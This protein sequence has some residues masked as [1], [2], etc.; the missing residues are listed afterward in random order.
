M[1][2]Y[3]TKTESMQVGGVDTRIRSLLD[4]QQYAD[5]QGVALRAGIS[6]ASWPLFGLVWPSALVLAAHVQ[7]VPLGARRVL[8]IGCGLAL[9]SLV[10]HRR[11]GQVTASDRH[12]LA[13]EFLLENLRLNAMAALP[14]RCGDWL[15]RN[16]DLGRF[17]L[18]V[19]SDVLYERDQP[20]QL[21]AF[22][23]RHAQPC[24]EVI[25][26]D[27]D[28]G[29]RPAF[30]RNMLALGFAHSE[31]RIL[32]MP[33]GGGPYRGRLLNYRRQAPGETGP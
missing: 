7:H 12:P 33:A 15:G 31:S 29:N 20:D 18:I 32:A 27:P 21:S 22:I 2:G 11:Q 9:A 25:I 5:P 3:R 26:A 30:H 17:D 4:R 28:R 13:E 24:V 16:P 23:A 19:G 8:E 10:I 14:Y 1:P 6:S